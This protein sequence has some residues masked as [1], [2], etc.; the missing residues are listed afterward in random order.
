VGVGD[1]LEAALQLAGPIR[2]GT[3]HL[4][5]DG[6]VLQAAD[7][8]YEVIWRHD[9]IDTPV[10]QWTHHF[11]LPPAPVRFDAV[12]FEADA[13]GSAVPAAP[14]D[15]LVLRWTAMGGDAG[16][17]GATAFIPNGDGAHAHGR[18]PSLKIPR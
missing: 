18:I 4:I 11:E 10:V 17:G 12:P 15:K 3:W 1:S 14:G 16:A 5:G 2:S 6:I 8:Q 13:Q 7:L 9:G